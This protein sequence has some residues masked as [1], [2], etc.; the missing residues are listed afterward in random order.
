MAPH[1]AV[2]SEWKSKESG[3]AD[4][5]REVSSNAN[6][7]A[8]GQEKY[9][10]S[11]F[12]F[13]GSYSWILNRAARDSF[14]LPSPALSPCARGH[15]PTFLGADLHILADLSQGLGHPNVR[16]GAEQAGACSV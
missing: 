15:L 10:G 5:H 6:Q 11:L 4:F 9:Q 14:L 3:K 2:G 13:A 16:E 7:L 8:R 12:L 1:V